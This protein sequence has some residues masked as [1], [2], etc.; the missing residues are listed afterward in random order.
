MISSS[1]SFRPF[2]AHKDYTFVCILTVFFP[3]GDSDRINDPYPYHPEE[4]ESTFL[5]IYLLHYGVE[6]ILL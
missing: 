2:L 5:V 3:N 1:C 4:N 6:D